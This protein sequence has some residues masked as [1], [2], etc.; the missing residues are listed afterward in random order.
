MTE[1]NPVNQYDELP[2]VVERL[3]TEAWDDWSGTVL[4]QLIVEIQI[5]RETVPVEIQQCLDTHV[6]EFSEEAAVIRG[7]VELC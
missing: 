3:V 2:A 5:M 6:G 4:N 7:T 1:I